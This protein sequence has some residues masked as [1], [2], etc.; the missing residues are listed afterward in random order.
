MAIQTPSQEAPRW[1]L[2]LM[3]ESY[4]LKRRDQKKRGLVSSKYAMR[5]RE[6]TAVIAQSCF[7]RYSP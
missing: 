6:E 2:A 5:S 3:E 4:E 1:L 7:K